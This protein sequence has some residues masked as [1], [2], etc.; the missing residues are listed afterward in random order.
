MSSYPIQWD[1][2]LPVHQCQR[3][4]SGISASVE[5]LA[6]E[7]VPPCP[8]TIDLEGDTMPMP[9]SLHTMIDID[10][11]G[12]LASSLTVA[13]PETSPPDPSSFIWTTGGF[14]EIEIYILFPQLFSHQHQHHIITEQ[15]A[16]HIQLSSTAAQAEDHNQT[17]HKQSQVQEF[18][19]SLQSAELHH[20]WKHVQ[21]IIQ[22][23]GLQHFQ[24]LML[25]LTAKNLKLSTQH[26]IWSSTCDAFFHMWNQAVDG[27]YLTTSFYNIGK[28]YRVTSEVSDSSHVQHRSVE[29]ALRSEDE[30][31][32]QPELSKGG[33]D[34][35]D[36]DTSNLGEHS[37]GGTSVAD[38]QASD[39]EHEHL[40]K[41]SWCKQF[42]PLSFLH[43]LGFMTLELHQ[44]FLLH[45][46]GLLYCQFYNIIKEV[47]TASQHSPFANENL[48]ILAL[49]PRLVQ[50]P[51]ESSDMEWIQKSLG[52]ASTLELYDYAW[53]LDKLDWMA[54]TFKPPH[55]V[56][57]VFNTLTLQMAYYWQYQQLIKFKSDFV[58]FHDVFSH[59]LDVHLDPVCSVLL[60]QLLVNLCLR[61]FQKNVFRSLTDCVTQQPLHSARLENVCNDWKAD[62][63]SLSLDVAL[64]S[65]PSN[66]DVWLAIEQGQHSVPAAMSPNPAVFLLAVVRLSDCSSNMLKQLL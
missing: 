13:F 49:N 32:Y 52:M 12:G 64:P 36:E 22:D 4:Y 29:P 16:T 31:T 51:P 62:G 48:D 61:A 44:C 66:L 11:T 55:Q 41:E 19:F 24:R 10:S 20:L 39:S 6:H 5:P 65:V 25:L 59:M 42:Y 27:H 3:L 46:Q 34:E 7:K 60:L 30:D 50:P 38:A 17:L 23:P 56:H 45:Y 15:N 37:A 33:E 53:F 26:A 1:T 63:Q 57:M 2:I 35:D 14:P 21:T 8:T 54:M 28:K 9:A 18:Y 40:Q 43:D 58:L 47:F